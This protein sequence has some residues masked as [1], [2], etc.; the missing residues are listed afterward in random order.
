MMSPFNQ[1]YFDRTLDFLSNLN[2]K[3]FFFFFFYYSFHKEYSL[4]IDRLLVPVHIHNSIGIFDSIRLIM[5]VFEDHMTTSIRNKLVLSWSLYFILNSSMVKENYS[6]I[7][8]SLTKFYCFLLH[9]V[10]YVFFYFND[11]WCHKIYLCY[12]Y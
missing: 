5:V 11:F 6:T 1:T 8:L 3:L 9:L 2:S 7:T 4:T 12:I 10:K